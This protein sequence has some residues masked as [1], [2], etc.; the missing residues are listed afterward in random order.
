VRVPLWVVSK[1]AKQ[2]VVTSSKPADHVSTIKLIEQ[3]FG[4][5]TTLT[6][7]NHRFDASTPTGS[8]YATGGKPAPP[9]DGRPDISDLLDLFAF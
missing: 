4:I 9:R 7:E 5:G 6:A 2:G 1:Y 8:N 3:L